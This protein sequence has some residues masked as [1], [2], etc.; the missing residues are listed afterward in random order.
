MKLDPVLFAIIDHQKFGNKIKVGG[1]VIEIY[2]HIR[3]RKPGTEVLMS[4]RDLALVFGIS[5]NL[6]HNVIEFRKIQAELLD[7]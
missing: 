7:N 1:F 5:S 3:Q 6:R 2:Q 4:R